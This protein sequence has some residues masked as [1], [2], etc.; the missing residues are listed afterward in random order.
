MSTPKIPQTLSE[1]L[2]LTADLEDQKN[3]L[4]AQ[5]KE[6]APKV[7]V[8]ERISHSKDSMTFCKT[9]KVLGIGEHRLLDFLRIKQRIFARGTQPYADKVK[10][11]Y[12]SFRYHPITHKDGTVDKRPYSR[13]LPRGLY[14]LYR[15]LLKE[16]MVE[17]NQQLELAS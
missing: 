10:S 1:T 13:I 6:D 2:R 3:A 9:A 15:L 12:L 17:R 7:E 14:A 5:I 16:G 11:A 4:V 8:A